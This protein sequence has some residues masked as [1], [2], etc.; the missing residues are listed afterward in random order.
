M[1]FALIFGPSGTGKSTLGKECERHGWLHL[2]ADQFLATG[3]DGI[4]LLDLRAEWNAYWHRFDAVSLVDAVAARAKAAGRTGAVLTLPSLILP[5]PKHHDAAGALR[6]RF[7]ILFGSAGQCLQAAIERPEFRAKGLGAG[8]WHRH[9]DG[10]FHSITDP[11][12]CPF[13]LPA[14]DASGGRIPVL[15]LA[16]AIGCS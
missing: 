2:E 3:Q 13:L 10:L 12:L 11:F 4:D 15:E 14:W 16:R 6:L 5:S 8:H 7:F 9:N 1:D